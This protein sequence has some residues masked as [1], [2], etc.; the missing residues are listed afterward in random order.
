MFQPNTTFITSAIQYM[1]TPDISTV[2]NAKETPQQRA[3][4]PSP[5]RSCR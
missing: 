4:A 3:R 1:L 2:M 5:K